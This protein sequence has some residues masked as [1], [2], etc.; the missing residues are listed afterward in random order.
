MQQ[1]GESQAVKFGKERSKAL[2]VKVFP[3]IVGSQLYT[4]HPEGRNGSVKFS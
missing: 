3:S 2:A 1:H 4:V